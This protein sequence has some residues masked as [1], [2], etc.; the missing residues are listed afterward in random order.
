MKKNIFLGILIIVIAS[1]SVGAQSRY[2]ED[3]SSGVGVG[4]GFSFSDEATGFGAGFGYS[5]NG[6]IDIGVDLQR[7]S[8]KKE[9]TG[10]SANAFGATFSF[11]P[12]KQNPITPLSL[13]ISAGLGYAKYESED[14][15]I[16]GWNMT[17]TMFHFGI[18]I[19]HMFFIDSNFA[20]QPSAG[21][22]LSNI[23]VKI[24]DSFG[25]SIT[26]KDSEFGFGV[27]IAFIINTSPQGKFIITP[28]ISKGEDTTSFNLTAAYVFMF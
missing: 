16:L 24:S 21:I 22:S 15:D 11:F 13:S 27:D 17:A 8:F 1:L 20:I 19:Y 23:S 10:F 4:A 9:L 6:N 14:L 25:D 3:R 26:D 5:V 2:I 7:F 12:L 28:A 18:S